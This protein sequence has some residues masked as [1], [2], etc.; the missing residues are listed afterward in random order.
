MAVG[1]KSSDIRTQ[2]LIEAVILSIT[3]G[4]VGI[5]TGIGAGFALASFMKAPPIFTVSSIVLAV[6]F[7]ALVGTGF[8]YYPAAKA[9][10]LNPIDALKYE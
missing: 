6:V 4:I 10:K 2:F 9:S 8:G 5:I 3:G 1:A 7:S